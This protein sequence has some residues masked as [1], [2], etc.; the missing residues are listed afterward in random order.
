MKRTKRLFAGVAITLASA[1]MVFSSAAMVPSAS[2]AVTPETFSL[3]KIANFDTRM[4]SADGGVAEIVKYNT[5]NDKLYLVNGKTQTLDIVS[6]SA[7]GTDGELQTSFDENTDRISF[8]DIVSEHAEDFADGFEVGDITSVD[9]NTDKDVVAVALQHSDYASDGA[10]VL[11]DY[12][13]GY[14]AAY[15]AGVQPDMLVF[16]GDK[17]LTANEGEPRD[18]YAAGAVDP[19][20]SVT[21]VDLSAGTES[22]TTETIGFD[23]FD[24]DRAALVEDNV[25]IKKNSSPSTDFEPEYIAVSGDTAYV[26][27]QEANAIATLDL[28]AGEFTS[29]KSLGF[30]DHSAAGNELDL[31]KDSTINIRTEDVYGIYMP[32]GID[33]FTAGGKTYIATANEGDA[34]EWGSG[35]NEYAGIEDR[36]FIDQSG[37]E[38]VSVEVEALKNDEWDGLLADDADA[39]YMLGGRSFS[40]FDAETME[41]VYDSGSTIERT[42][43]ADEEHNAYFNCSNDDVKLDSRAK[44]K[45]PEPEAVKIAETEGN[46]YAYVALE[47]QGGIM[48]YDI[49]DLE[50][51]S[52]VTYTSTRDYS[53]DI[54][55]DVAPE[56][57]DYVPAAESPADKDL[58]VLANEVSGTVAVYA[59]ED[60]AKTYTMHEE[61]K[62]LEV[63]NAG[64]VLISTVY[65]SGGKN[66]SQASSHDFIALVNP[67]DEPIYMTGWT[68]GYSTM[69]DAEAGA[70]RVW[71]E[72]TLNTVIPAGGEYVIL[73][74]ACNN[75]EEPFVSFAPGEYN[76]VW[77]DLSIDNKQYSVRLLDDNGNV[78]DALGIG[79]DSE[80]GEGTLN[81]EE[82]NK[83]SYVVRNGLT[84]TDNNVTDFTV[85]D[86]RDVDPADYAEYKPDAGI[87]SDSASDET[88]T[89]TVDTPWAEWS[90]EVA[91]GS[92]ITLSLTA[93]EGY[94]ITGVTA[95]GASL[96]PVDGKY[97]FT[98]T[99][100]TEVTVSA[101]ASDT[102]PSVPSDDDAG[103]T[104]SDADGGCGGAIAGCSVLVAAGVSALSAAVLFAFRRGKKGNRG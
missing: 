6:V 75:E 30:K 92:E 59:V 79:A 78:V 29:V 31:R 102:D 28:E 61:Y 69:R 52:V 70:E 40:V 34:R 89:V 80:T 8:G 39:I 83:H 81:T 87:L 37:D 3:N 63:D 27:L 57:I 32:D 66:D 65:G 12:D 7:Y 62:E 85:V 71:Q 51:V 10:I 16:A 21:I 88:F 43:A 5:D 90:Y 44:K 84:D 13:G 42:I 54:A 58:V 4:S 1:A 19:R 50:N 72:L 25:L 76:A 35:D 95:G 26:A 15:E 18:G 14:I 68:L 94:E 100:D 11:L 98:V 56:S 53:E 33:V 45:G 24:D 55:G 22:G 46:T 47:R 60:T 36:T 99:A 74:A 23:A 101:T 77:S 97:S 96:V 73:G 49:T 67:T 86:M 64:N 48:V 17:V 41:L 9:V 38:P 2:A 104:G 82:L 93:A 91:G 103:D 20:G